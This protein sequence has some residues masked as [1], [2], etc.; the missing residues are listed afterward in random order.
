[1]HPHSRKDARCVPVFLRDRKISRNVAED[2]ERTVATRDTR[3]TLHPRFALRARARARVRAHGHVQKTLRRR[4]V[5]PLS[6]KNNV[7]SGSRRTRA[8]LLIRSR[9]WGL[10]GVTY[11][12][13]I[14]NGR[15]SNPMLPC[16]G[17]FIYMGESSVSPIL[18][19]SSNSTGDV[20]APSRKSHDGD[21]L[22]TKSRAIVTTCDRFAIRI[23][24]HL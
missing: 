11:V 9:G 16:Q 8:A 23:H 3:K 24:D 20:H 4:H 18:S 13:G 15:H 1:V 19:F 12:Y 2:R 22:S 17:M 6:E 21:L 7:Q 5:H 14:R 10:E